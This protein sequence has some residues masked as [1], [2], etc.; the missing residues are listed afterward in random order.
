MGRRSPTRN[1]KELRQRWRP[2]EREALAHLLAG[3][4]G[5]CRN[6]HSHRTVNLNDPVEAREQ[7]ML[8]SHLLRIVDVR[9]PA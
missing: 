2:G 3:A 5:P 9:R 4:I 6:P 7:V 1:T 8:A